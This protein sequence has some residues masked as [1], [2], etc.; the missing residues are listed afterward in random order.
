VD[1]SRFL[2]QQTIVT[3]W[4]AGWK[5]KGLQVQPGL[6]QAEPAASVNRRRLYAGPDA[7]AQIGCRDAAFLRR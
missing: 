1:P 7:V 3:A 2:Q 6:D 5:K 4:R